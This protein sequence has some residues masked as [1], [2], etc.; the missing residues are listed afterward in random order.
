MKTIHLMPNVND[1]AVHH[2]FLMVGIYN[3]I[4]KSFLMVDSVGKLFY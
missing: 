1:W 4:L 2:I 3:K